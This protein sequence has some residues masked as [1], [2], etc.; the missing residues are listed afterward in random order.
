LQKGVETRFPFKREPAAP[1][2]PMDDFMRLFGPNGA[3]EQFFAQNLRAVVDTS[4]KPWKPLSVEG[5]PPAISAADVAQF[6]R[7]AAIRDA[8]FPAAL[9]GQPAVLRFELVPL[10][11]DAA[12]KGATLTADGAP[13]PIPAGAAGAP[14][15]AVPLQWPSKAAV[16][17]SFDGEP[18]TSAI[19]A[20]G[21]WA[22]MRFVS[23]GR[24]QPTSVPDRMRLTM[25]SGARTAEFELRT[26]S[27]VHPF[28]LRDLAEF[29]CPQLAP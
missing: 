28:S 14:G 21:P 11:L 19:V 7:A 26:G 5:A 4:Q 12:A 6:Q 3:F 25:S 27:I 29:R 20:D 18:P 16:S 10:G 2:M 1:D 17:L 13:N 24:L 9:P 15:R 23:R 8:F 22:A